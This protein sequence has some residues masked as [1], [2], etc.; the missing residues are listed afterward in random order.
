MPLRSDVYDVFAQFPFEE[1]SPG[2]V[3]LCK[4][5]LGRG[6]VLTHHVQRTLESLAAAGSLPRVADEKFVRHF[7]NWLE[8]IHQPYFKPVITARGRLNALLALLHH[9]LGSGGRGPVLRIVDF[10]TGQPPYTTMDLAESFPEA[11]I[12]GVDLYSPTHMVRRGD[13]AYAL[14][15]GGRLVAVHSADARLLHAM[16]LNWE[17]TKLEFDRLRAAPH[18]QAEVVRNPAAVLLSRCPNRSVKL[19]CGRIGAFE[20]PAAV[21]ETVDVIWSFNCLLH[22]PLETRVRALRTWI[23]RLRQGGA[24]MEGYTSPTGSHAVYCLWKR[25]G[26]ALVL[27][28]FGFTLT[29]L[30]YPLWPLYERDPQIEMLNSFLRML[31]AADDK[32]EALRA[33][34]LRCR[35]RPSG[36]LTIAGDSLGFGKAPS[37]TVTGGGYPQYVR[38]A[39]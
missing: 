11:A 32:P 15:E 5:A 25:S 28:E 30:H 2:G 36:F 19:H 29:N 14:Y 18:S 31:H 23:S 38:C 22:Y 37:I 27:R 8:I 34:G 10:G 7:V 33:A 12:D 4:A 20:L 35:R 6:F 24:V 26:N 39:G 17:R 9:S 16:I 1:I 21:L 3:D 13:G